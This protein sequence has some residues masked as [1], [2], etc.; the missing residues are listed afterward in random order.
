MKKTF[1]LIG[2]LLV[3]SA[4][5]KPEPAPVPP[6]GGKIFKTTGTDNLSLA[7]IADTLTL[8]IE[9]AQTITNI[10]GQTEWLTAEYLP[11]SN[12]L[13]VTVAKN[14]YEYNRTDGLFTSE[15]RETELILISEENLTD[16]LKIVQKP[17]PI[18]KSLVVGNDTKPID[19]KLYVSIDEITLGEHTGDMIFCIIDIY[20]QYDEEG[21]LLT[22]EELS[23]RFIP[24]L[25]SGES[26]YIAGLPAEVHTYQEYLAAMENEG[27]FWALY[28]MSGACVMFY[29]T[30]DDEG[31]IADDLMMYENLPHYM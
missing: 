15:P 19:D 21:N 17:Y 8:Q 12:E 14:T 16:T 2:L 20:G 31:N 28:S 23:E 11:E 6:I 22:S 30:V 29:L 27:E 7:F 24:F 26:G 10:E 3:A 18:I 13:S 25:L 4:C 5:D 1:L 9:D